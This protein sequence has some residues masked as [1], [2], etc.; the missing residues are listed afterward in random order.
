MQWGKGKCRAR[1][2]GSSPHSSAGAPASR[3]GA[4]NRCTLANDLFSSSM[5][6]STTR[7]RC[8]TRFSPCNLEARWEGEK[9]LTTTTKTW[10]A[11][12]GSP[13][14]QDVVG[15]NENELDVGALLGSLREQVCGQLAHLQT[16]NAMPKPTYSALARERNKTGLCHPQHHCYSSFALREQFNSNPWNVTREARI[17]K[18]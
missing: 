2:T 8:T 7:R 11:L 13:H 6:H 16:R 10:E 12:E 15:G 5:L 4:F 3:R 9:L 14:V 17:T 1:G 18:N